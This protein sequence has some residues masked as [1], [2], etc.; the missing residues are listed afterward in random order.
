MNWSEAHQA[1]KEGKKVSRP[2]WGET[3]L[4]RQLNGIVFHTPKKGT[5]MWKHWFINY[6]DVQLFMG[7]NDFY[8]KEDV[9]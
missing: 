2:F 9:K 7:F 1:I 8:I 4:D 6:G 5:S 3:Y